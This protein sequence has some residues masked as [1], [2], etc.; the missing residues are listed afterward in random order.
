MTSAA[1]RSS[2]HPQHLK[3]LPH[4]TKLH[5]HLIALAF[6]QQGP[7]QRG[8]AA[9]DLNELAAAEQLHAA[10]IGAKKEVLPLVLDINQADQRAQLDALAA[11]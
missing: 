8:F 7:A 1:Q 5:R 2:I 6:A 3:H 9:D 10:A 11:S 4:S